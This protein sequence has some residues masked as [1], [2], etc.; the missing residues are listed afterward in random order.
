MSDWRS[1]MTP[2]EFRDKLAL[3]PKNPRK[4]YGVIGYPIKHSAS[5]K[6]HR[7]WGEQYNKRI[8]YDAIEAPAGHF[9]EVAYDFFLYGGRGLNV[10]VPHKQ[11]AFRICNELSERA[12][13]CGAV[14][15]LEQRKDGTFFGDNSDGAGLVRDLTVN[16][17]LDLSGI[18]IAVIGAGG[19]ARGLLLPL[20]ELAPASLVLANRSIKRAQQ[21]AS[22]LQL[23]DAIETCAMRKLANRHFDLVIN[24][25]SAG[26]QGRIPTIPT[27][28]ILQDSTCYDLAYGKAANP[29]MSY[30]KRKGAAR[31]LDGWGMLVEQAAESFEVWHRLRPDTAHVLANRERFIPKGSGL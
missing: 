11:I 9:S 14:N 19:A 24:A 30:A 16:Q 15:L 31:V 25:T 2:E 12:R 10:T 8:R 21:I 17:K 28:I 7:H 18:H 26:L 20:L 13:A 23:A 4:R 29:F 1:G 5:P 27:E 22:E 3:L 6:I